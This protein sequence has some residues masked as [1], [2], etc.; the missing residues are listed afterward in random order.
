MSGK[1][2]AM[3]ARMW[4]ALFFLPAVVNATPPES[5]R[6]LMADYCIRCHD[7]DTET[8]LNLAAASFDLNDRDSFRTWVQV[9]DQVES[10]AMPPQEADQPSDAERR[11]VANE[12]KKL[13]TDASRRRIESEGRVPVRRLTRTEYDYT[14]R[15]LFSIEGDFSSQL[16]EESSE[17]RFDTV[18]ASQRFSAAHLDAYLKTAD[19]VLDTALRLGAN[20][21]RSFDFDLEN[22]PHLNHFHE[23]ELRTGGSISLRRDQGVVIF[24]DVNYLV[25]SDQIGFL[26]RANGSGTYRIT[27]TARAVQSDSP[28]AMKLVTKDVS[29]ES[30][31]VDAVDLLP[32]QTQVV[33]FNVWLNRTKVFYISLDE[34]QLPVEILGNILV[35]GGPQNY[36]GTG[37]H[38]RS[39]HVEGPLVETWPP[40]STRKVLGDGIGLVKDADSG[41]FELQLS[42]SRDEH[43]RDTVKRLAPRLFRRPVTDDE[44]EAF[45]GLADDSKTFVDAVRGSLRAML[46]SPQFLLLAGRAGVLDDFSLASRL[47]YFLWKAPPDQTLVRMAAEDRLSQPKVL[48]A[49]V[50]RLLDDERSRRFV[51][52]FTNQWLRLNR[53]DETTPDEKLYPEFDRLL[54]WS[55]SRET[56]RFLGELIEKNLCVSNLIDS[57]FV[58]L[59]RRLAE[60]Y[61]IEG[62]VGQKF[63]RV[64]LSGDSVR[65]GLLTHASVL[66]VT[67][68]GLTT[69]PVKRGEFVLS[70]LLGTPPPPA[71]ANVGSIEPDTSGAAT[72]RQA[73]ARHRDV[74][75]CAECHRRIDPPGF[76]LESFDPTG[77]F[78]T[79][80]RGS[81]DEVLALVKYQQ[82]A[83]VDASGTMADGTAFN[84]IREYRDELMKRRDEVARH[85]IEMLMAYGTGG[86]IQFAD[87][88][89]VDEIFQRTSQN[90]FPIRSIIHE[91]IQSRMF[92]NR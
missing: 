73:L 38:I 71:P 30:K 25:R 90:N 13:L 7:A 20:P 64:A 72:I 22:S 29:G 23:R 17:T 75:S 43:V 31:L 10:Q 16:P 12:L 56:E 40:L 68:N 3:F 82:G 87:R 86:D 91:V 26:V 4:T 21:Y 74:E 50:D 84:D 35:A 41:S 32:G 24:R 65:G 47:S 80:Y 44:V 53:L 61:G 55:L 45:V 52:D 76:A 2:R 63:R 28:V 15:D 37:L 11:A 66:K 42:R 48:A 1:T 9:F 62:I 49:Q 51:R 18:G 79:H 33:V 81:F 57:D 85:F 59:N 83:K 69:S 60:H 78:R 46:T 34:E 5:I 39:M 89:E 19:R 36:D 67:A 88:G 54:H 58:M 8:R 70:E 92:R 77:A 27:V 14:V 6:G